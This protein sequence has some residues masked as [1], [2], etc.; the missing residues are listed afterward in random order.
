MTNQGITLTEE[1]KELYFYTKDHFST[2]LENEAQE[3]AV[4]IKDSSLEEV[5][6]ICPTLAE[7]IITIRGIVKRS[8]DK[9]VIDYCTGGESPFSE[10]DFQQVSE[11]ICEEVKNNEL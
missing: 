3:L 8:I 4:H 6:R 11:K 2:E 7:P 5:K 1:G 10:T 9:Y